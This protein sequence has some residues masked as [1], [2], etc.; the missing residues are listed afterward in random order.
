MQTG[1]GQHPPPWNPGVTARFLPWPFAYMWDHA[2]VARA[3]P[4]ACP[5]PDSPYCW[6]RDPVCITQPC[7][8]ILSCPGCHCV[9]RVAMTATV[10]LSLPEVWV[11]CRG[12]SSTPVQQPHQAAA[13]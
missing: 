8:H 13:E 9:N 7:G 3:P 2:A 5:W 6:A 12:A 10:A 11:R 1:R 4:W